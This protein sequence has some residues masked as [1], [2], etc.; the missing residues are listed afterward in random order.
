MLMFSNRQIK[1]Q[2]HFLSYYK[3]SSYP[4]KNNCLETFVY[5]TE[6]DLSRSKINFKKWHH[7]LSFWSLPYVSGYRK[8]ATVYDRENRFKKLW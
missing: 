4:M 1:K 8:N 6:N 3:F 2:I 5:R 7:F